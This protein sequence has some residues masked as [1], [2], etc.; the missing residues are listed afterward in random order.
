MV[1]LGQSPSD[2]LERSNRPM[3][4]LS[5][6]LLLIL[7]HSDILADLSKIRRRAYVRS[8]FEY[9]MSSL[10][11]AFVRMFPQSVHFVHMSLVILA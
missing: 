11:A 1:S 5:F 4:H 10:D 6:I 2:S 8:I 9:E 7:K 3:I